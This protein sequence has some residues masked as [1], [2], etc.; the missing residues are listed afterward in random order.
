MYA[1]KKLK[2]IY[3]MKCYEIKMSLFELIKNVFNESFL[4]FKSEILDEIKNIKL[5]NDSVETSEYEEYNLELQQEIMEL[6]RE[7]KQI[8]QEYKEEIS[9]I[10]NLY[11]AKIVESDFKQKQIEELI[12][13]NEKNK[14]ISEEKILTLSREVENY[15]ENIIELKKEYKKEIL[16]LKKEIDIID[17]KNKSLKI[18]NKNLKLENEELKEKCEEKIIELKKEIYNVNE[19]LKLENENLKLENK[20][21]KLEN[22]DLINTLIGDNL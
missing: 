17:E 7:N 15:K 14:E 9:T 10:R 2:N 6:K 19:N 18:K 3:I 22:N 1:T 8:E 12:Y 5:K 4:L 16:E 11:D 20:K 21:L 13:E